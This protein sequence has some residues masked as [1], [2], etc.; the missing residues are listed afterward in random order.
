MKNELT[1][2]S[3]STKKLNSSQDYSKDK[4]TY[5]IY[6]IAGVIALGVFLNLAVNI[7]STEEYY[8][9]YYVLEDYVNNYEDEDSDQDSDDYEEIDNDEETQSSE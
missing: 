2:N 6:Y 3:I 5:F 8:E 4:N 1:N 9:K 7:K